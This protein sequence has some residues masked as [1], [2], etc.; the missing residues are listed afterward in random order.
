[1]TVNDVKTVAPWN[2]NSDGF[3]VGVGGLV[4]DSFVM[5]NDDNIKVRLI[6]DSL[7]MM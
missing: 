4:E 6:Q 5:A 7:I 3:E 1:M 2:A